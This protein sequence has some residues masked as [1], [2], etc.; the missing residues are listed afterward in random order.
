MLHPKQSTLIF[1]SFY[2]E[3][4][5]F[6]FEWVAQCDNMPCLIETSFYNTEISVSHMSFRIRSTVNIVHTSNQNVRYA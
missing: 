3:S 5:T 6:V 4:R 2:E 1:I